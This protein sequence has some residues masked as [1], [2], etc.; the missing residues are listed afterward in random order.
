M[1]AALAKST[2]NIVHVEK[3]WLDFIVALCGGLVQVL[4]YDCSF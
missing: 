1:L 3:S 4:Q 2:H